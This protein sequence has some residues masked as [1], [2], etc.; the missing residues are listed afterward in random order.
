MKKKLEEKCVSLPSDFPFGLNSSTLTR[1]QLANQGYLMK[2]NIE[3][4]TAVKDSYC[5]NS[6]QW[7]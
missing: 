3:I 6:Q 4:G 2:L 1:V 7:C 5:L